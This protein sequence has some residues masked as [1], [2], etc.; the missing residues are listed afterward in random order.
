MK[1]IFSIMFLWLAALVTTAQN[2]DFKIHEGLSQLDYQLDIIDSLTYT[3]VTPLFD[4]YEMQELKEKSETELVKEY[5][6]IFLKEGDCYKFHDGQEVQF[7]C[8]LDTTKDMKE[9]SRY[10]FAGVYCNQALIY[11]QGYEWWDYLSVDLSDRKTVRLSGKPITYN[12]ETLVA[13]GYDYGTGINVVDL[14]S[15][16]QITIG[17]GDWE[18]S[19]SKQTVDEF[20]FELKKGNAVDYRGETKY[21]RIKLK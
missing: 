8:S 10:E 4:S 15:K 9:Y 2:G 6:E 18:V 3:S 21:I 11:R 20:Y 12:C 16:N 19:E 17:T 1:L 5:P 13:Y 7:V 14:Q